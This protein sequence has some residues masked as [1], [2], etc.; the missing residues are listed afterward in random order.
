MNVS[1]TVCKI[2]SLFEFC[3]LKS[4]FYHKNMACPSYNLEILNEITYKK[5]QLNEGVNAFSRNY[6]SEIR[7]S[8]EMERR[9]R[10]LDQ[11]ITIYF[12]NFQATH[13]TWYC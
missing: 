2:Y 4:V 7:R 10:K 6:V 12:S 1:M 11:V 8:E 9:L 13:V 5:S 3:L